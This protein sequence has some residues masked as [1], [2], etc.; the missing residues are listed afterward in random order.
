[1][2]KIF[3]EEIVVLL[4]ENNMVDLDDFIVLEGKKFYVIM[5][6][7]VNGVGKIIIIGK[8]VY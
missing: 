6:V 7:G 3:C 4:I 2:N 8:L 5:V 1:M